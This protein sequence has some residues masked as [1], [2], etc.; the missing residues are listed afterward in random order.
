MTHAQARAIDAGDG[1]APHPTLQ[2]GAIAAAAA[3]DDAA[4]DEIIRLYARRV[5]AMAQS[6]LRDP[7][8]AEEIT[9][10]VFA[11]LVEALREGR[12]R[13][14]G[15]FE[16]WLFRVTMNRV[17]DAA[18]GRV[19]Q[20]MNTHAHALNLGTPNAAGPDHAGAHRPAADTLAALRHAMEGLPPADREV[21]ELRHHG[22]LGFRQI[23]DLLKEPVGTLLARHHR[24]LRKLRTAL[25]SAGIDPDTLGGAPAASR[26]LS[27]ES[28]P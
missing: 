10:S 2:P 7:E 26:D 9:Q 28:K 14:D 24:A 13:E 1:S 3:G 27:E 11:T 6:R 18:R 16:A 19:R 20:A 12:Y 8:A 15:R 4:W 5:F 21:L 23:A 22:G 17:R 25:E